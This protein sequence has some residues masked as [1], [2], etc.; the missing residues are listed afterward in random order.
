MY[1]NGR[2]RSAAEPPTAIDVDDL[3]ADVGGGRGGQESG[4]GCVIAVEVGLADPARR[5]GADDVLGG[6]GCVIA[7]EVGFDEAR[8]DGVH[9][10]AL[11]RQFAGQAPGKPEQT[12]L[13]RRVCGRT[14]P[15][16]A[17]VG[18]DGTDGHDSPTV[19][20]QVRDGGLNRAEGPA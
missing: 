8:R 11:R 9:G 4:G 5:D 1:N 7:V 14:W 19:E 20:S 16:S 13:G 3:A 18:S 6:G 12:G 10:G 15:A 17:A 2:G